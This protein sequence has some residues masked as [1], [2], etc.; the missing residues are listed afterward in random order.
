MTEDAV[1]REIAL[2]CTAEEAFARFADEIGAWWPHA[3]SANGAN[4]ADVMMEPKPGR[5]IFETTDRR[6]DNPDAAIPR[7]GENGV[8]G[9]THRGVDAAAGVPAGTTSNYFRTRAALIGGVVE[10]FA[11]RER[12]N[13]D[14]LAAAAY[15]TTPKELAQTLA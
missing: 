7:L 11:A 2:T 9:L 4:L 1:V 3:F 13:F 15:P 12:A 8:R 6:D 10:R 14:E 5:R